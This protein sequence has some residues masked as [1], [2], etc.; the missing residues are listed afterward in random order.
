M[1]P[2]YDPSSYR[3]SCFGVDLCLKPPALLWLCMLFLSRSLVMPIIIG[4]GHFAGVNQD[5][6]TSMRGLWSTAGLLPALASAPVLFATLRR[7]AG[8][9]DFVRRVWASG[10][11]LLVI[12]ALIDLGVAI[13]QLA[14][15]DRFD[16]QAMT[17]LCTATAD[18]YF[19]VYLMAARRVRDTF[20]DFP[21]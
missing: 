18:A 8:A 2:S 4:I 7:A 20:S 10:R 5:A 21:V 19:I 11:A 15:P 6:L 14:R 16:G 3:D 12:A 9:G 17:A 1:R 13:A